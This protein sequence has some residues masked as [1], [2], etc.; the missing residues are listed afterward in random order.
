[1]SAKFRYVS[2]SV[3]GL[4]FTVVA[5]TI[6][7]KSDTSSPPGSSAPEGITAS[8]ILAK[9]FVSTYFQDLTWPSL[10]TCLLTVAAAVLLY[11]TYKLLFTPLNRI[12]MLG[13]VGYI[14][15]GKMTKKE[16]V[17]AVRK[18]RLVGDI[19]PVYP[20]GWF[21]LLESRD[22]P[23]KDSKMVSCLGKR[24]ESSLKR[25][26]TKNSEKYY[27]HIMFVRVDLLQLC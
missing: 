15:E 18:R 3:F 10:W 22:L 13:D 1:M 7:G 6:A 19:P 12:R 5:W 27:V 11:Y 8:Y 9:V 25:T 4:V 2:L 21:C 17:N 14:A 24:E 23:V 20:N 26:Y 16:L